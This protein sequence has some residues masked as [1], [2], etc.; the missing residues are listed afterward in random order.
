MLFVKGRR[1]IQRGGEEINTARDNASGEGILFHHETLDVY[2]VSLEAAT[3]FC[4]SESVSSLSNSV[5]RR[6]DEL[7]TSMVLN[8]AEGNGRF[9]DADQVRFLGTSH[10]SA[11]K[12]AARLDLCVTQSMLPGDVVAGWKALLERVSVM[13]ASMIAG[14]QR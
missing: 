5:F 2:R 3:A 1:S 13:T 10:E 6:L 7:F 14:I 12:V 9:S 8:I 11:V 4:C